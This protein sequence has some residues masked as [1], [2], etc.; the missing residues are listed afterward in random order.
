MQGTP[1]G[2]KYQA[3]QEGCCWKC[4]FATSNNSHCAVDLPGRAG[5][6]VLHLDA[7]RQGSV[8][9]WGGG[10][11]AGGIGHQHSKIQSTKEE[12][13]EPELLWRG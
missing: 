11:G 8:L 3:G 5:A 1:S 13:E 6:V 10:E 12:N 9:L 7:P 4:C 2:E